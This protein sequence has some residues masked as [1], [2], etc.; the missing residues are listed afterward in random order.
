MSAKFKFFSILAIM[1]LAAFFRFWGLTQIPP[2]LYPDEAMNGNNALEA[3][4]HKDWKV[5]YPEN[6][7][8]EG[9]FINVQSAFIY[10]L[11]NKP[12]VC[13]Y[14]PPYSG[15]SRFWAYIFLPSRYLPN[16]LPFWPL[17]F[18]PQVFGTS[19]F[20][21][22]GFGLSWRRSFWSGLYIFY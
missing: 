10:F 3:I 7:G 13:A 12:W 22:S 1:L 4:A 16:G 14:P 8:R 15:H 17:F 6:N 21:G 20:R 2:G 19:I 9:F 5:F 11:G 18:S